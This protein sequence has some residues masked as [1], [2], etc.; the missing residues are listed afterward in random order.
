M[1]IKD[2]QLYK[3]CFAASEHKTTIT[4]SYEVYNEQIDKSG[5]PYVYHP[6]HLAE[7]MDTAETVIVAL[8]ND[9]VRE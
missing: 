3:E 4:V 9:I 8:L 1:V 2:A 6:F 7:R 5:M